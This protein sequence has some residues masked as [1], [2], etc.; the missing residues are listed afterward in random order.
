MAPP[1]YAHHFSSRNIPFGVA[2]S[3]QNNKPQVV[4]R[5]EN[6]VLL[7]HSLHLEGFFSEV[8]GLAGDVLS[9]PTVNRLATLPKAVHQG[10]RKAVG[11]A[12]DKGGLDAFPRHSRVDV[13]DATMHLPVEVRDFIG[14]ADTLTRSIPAHHTD[15]PDFSC[16]LEHVKNAGRIINNNA[17]PPPAFFNFPVGYQGRASSVVVSGTDIERPI[18]Q[19]KNHTTGEIV[20]GPSG[21][22]D[23]ELEFAAIVGK[24]LPMGK[25]LLATEADEHIFGFS[26]LNDWSGKLFSSLRREWY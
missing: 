9:Q 14:K 3:G 23:Y 21:K 15:W 1:D 19:Y 16:S 22:V 6:T 11:H 12:F 4:T 24:P 7:L 17:N 8:E 5:I 20:V 18:G 2:S 26:L 25:R 10:V 13:S